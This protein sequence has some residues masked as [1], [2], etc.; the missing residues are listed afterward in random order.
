MWILGLKGLNQTRTRLTT[1]SGARGW[2]SVESIRLPAMWLGSNP[3]V[4][5]TFIIMWV[6]LVLGSLLCPEFIQFFIS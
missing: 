4:N 3:G 1:L 5:A 2:R 6:E